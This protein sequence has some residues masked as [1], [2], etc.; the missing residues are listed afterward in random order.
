MSVSEWK[1]REKEQ[2]RND[3]IDAAE[4]L[5]FSRGFD[6]VSM[7]DIA[8]AIS[9]NKATL[10]RYFMSKEALFFTVVLRGIRINYE[11]LKY[12]KNSG[13]GMDRLLAI[14]SVNCDFFK[15]YPDYHRLITYFSSGRFD[16]CKLVRSDDVACLPSEEYV[17]SVKLPEAVDGKIASEVSRLIASGDVASLPSNDQRRWVKLAETT[18]SEVVQEISRLRWEMFDMSRAAVKVGQEDGSIYTSMGSSELSILIG[19]ISTGLVNISPDYL[20]LMDY[21]KI[22]RDRFLLDSRKFLRHAISMGCN[23]E[24]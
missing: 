17:H 14:G 24:L 6:N 19:V 5:F 9:L 22:D 2:R 23:G 21:L 4:K 15:Q 1:A 7:D 18:E 12:A 11:M 13:T 3:I 20:S 16:L 8:K 10:Y